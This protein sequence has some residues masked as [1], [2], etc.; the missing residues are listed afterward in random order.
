MIIQRRTTICREEH[1]LKHL[2]I[3]NFMNYKNLKV[4]K[5]ILSTY[6]T[7]VLMDSIVIKL[8]SNLI[9]DLPDFI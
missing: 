9:L 2:I 5:I 7:K 1:V 3:L 6:I 4:E 8:S